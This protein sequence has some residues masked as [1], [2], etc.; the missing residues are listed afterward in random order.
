[1]GDVEVII[2]V[3]VYD[4][5]DQTTPEDGYTTATGTDTTADLTVTSA[6]GD[7]PVFFAAVRALGPGSMAETNYTERVDAVNTVSGSSSQHQQIG[8]GEGTGAASVAFT[9]TITATAVNG[10]NALGLNL[11]AAPAGPTAALSGTV[12]PSATESEIVAGG[13]TVILTLTDDTWVA[14]GATFNAQRQ[15]IINGIVSAQSETNGWNA[16]RSNIG[17]TAVARTSSTV[18]TITLPA[19]ANYAITATETL[20]VTI[21]ATALVGG[22]AIVASPTF[23]ITATAAPGTVVGS[24]L[25]SKHL[26]NPFIGSP[27]VR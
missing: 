26:G 21:P 9:G 15:N 11:N 20:T 8:G 27:F 10:W 1:V 12:E 3:A 13:E 25:K 5:V 6:T 24:L 7:T 2:T 23:Q 19:L 16:E 22:E 14:N 17:V 4:D 18:V